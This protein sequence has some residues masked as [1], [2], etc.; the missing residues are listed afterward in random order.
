VDRNGVL[1]G[2]VTFEQVRRA[3]AAAFPAR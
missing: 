2:V 3:V 1:A